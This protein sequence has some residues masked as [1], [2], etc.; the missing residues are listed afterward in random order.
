[1]ETS[2]AYLNMVVFAKPFL[3]IY[4]KGTLFFMAFKVFTIQL[5]R[6]W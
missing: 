4:V 3:E 5:P 6:L 1:M 2:V